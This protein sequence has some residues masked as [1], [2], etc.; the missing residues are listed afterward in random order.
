MTEQMISLPCNFRDGDWYDEA[1]AN[2]AINF[3]ENYC[4]HVKAYNGRFLLEDWQKNDIICPLFGWKRADGLRKYRT[5]YVEIPRKNGKSS[6]TAAIALYM[7]TGL[8]EK[9][10]EI[11]SAAGDT[12][13]ARIVFDVAQGMVQQSRSLS[14]ACRVLRNQINY[15]GSFYKSIS[16]EAKTK[17]GFNCSGV[18][19]DE[20]HTQPNRE[21]WDVLTTSI[22]SREQPIVI[23][24][25]TAGHD[26]SSICFEQHEYALGVR[27]GKIDD[28]TYLPV[29]YAA[30]ANDPWDDEKTWKKA[31]PGYGTICRKDYFIDQRNKAKAA[32]SN[33]NTFKRLNLNIWTGAN[34]AWISDEE[35]MQ[36]AEALPSDEYLATLPCY[37]GLDLAST[38][39]LTAFA[40]VWVDEEKTY[41]KVHQ[42][43]NEESVN[44]KRISGG[45]DYR[46]WEADGSLTITDGNV[47]DYGWVKDYIVRAHHQFNFLA[48]GYDRKFSTYITP[49]LEDE[50]VPMYPFGQGFY[51]MSYPTKQMEMAIVAG[52]LIHGGNAC[53]RWQFGC[54]VLSRDPADNIKVT[55]N[56]NKAGQQVDGVVASIMAFGEM[57]KDQEKSETLE[58]FT[59]Q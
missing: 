26:T 36:G 15:K 31:N 12:A 54:V 18:I 46:Q 59:L 16:S 30:D 8:G 29:I 43:I 9:G 40:M 58:I 42:F 56:K 19:F 48:V 3:I 14:K 55:K 53:L 50:G 5:C 6:L 22:G 45:I 28:P 10:A 39:D 7:L 2:H 51:D 47:T 24:L 57:L 38:R 41:L 44:T 35:F 13:Q 52:R 37:G 11:I 1:A 21:L 33:I 25:T 27:D 4:S 49:Q 17:H 20:L 23:A 34:E 32:P